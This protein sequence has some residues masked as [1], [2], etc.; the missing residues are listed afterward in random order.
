METMNKFPIEHVNNKW[1][2][3][4]TERDFTRTQL[5]NH[6]LDVLFKNMK[7]DE[8]GLSIKLH[9]S[10]YDTMYISYPL[11]AQDKSGQ[12]SQFIYDMYVIRGVVF[13]NQNEA[14]MFRE[15]LLK[16]YMWKELQR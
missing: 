1:Y 6:L 15:Y 9:G 11:W 5:K 13:K 14:E 7:I 3:S 12:Y 4:W 8:V 2:V 16:T 10:E